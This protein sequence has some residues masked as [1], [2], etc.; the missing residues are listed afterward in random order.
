MIPSLPK[1]YPIPKPSSSEGEYELKGDGWKVTANPYQYRAFHQGALVA[2][3]DDNAASDA[4]TNAQR[5][6]E[7]LRDHLKN[8]YPR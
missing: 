1:M 3:T 4:R 8:I 6:L 7:A 2:Y 5:A